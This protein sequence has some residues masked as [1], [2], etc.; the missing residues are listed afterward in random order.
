MRPDLAQQRLPPKT[1]AQKT[2][3]YTMQDQPVRSSSTNAPHSTREVTIP[4]AR[5]FTTDAW[6]DV[7][8]KRE[9]GSDD[10]AWFRHLCLE[11]FLDWQRKKIVG[12]ML[13]L[14]AETREQRSKQIQLCQP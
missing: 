6:P 3:K 1:A 2:L 10:F 13:R 4:L 8:E 14:R 11:Y 12:H 5:E 7:T 9:S